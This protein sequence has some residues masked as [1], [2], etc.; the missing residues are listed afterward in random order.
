MIGSLSSMEF[1]LRH[2][3]PVRILLEPLNLNKR[4]GPA[5]VPCFCERSLPGT[6]GHSRG[7]DWRLGHKINS[8][9]SIWGLSGSLNKH[10][11]FYHTCFLE[12]SRFPS[13]VEARLM[14]VYSDRENKTVLMSLSEGLMGCGREKK[15]VRE[16]KI[17]KQPIYVWI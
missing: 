10:C 2:W 1:S 11:T 12:R 8:I 3:D 13:Y 6:V 14:Y 16:W 5:E 4:L 15:S 9:C 7:S 17:L